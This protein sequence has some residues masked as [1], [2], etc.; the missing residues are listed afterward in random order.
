MKLTIIL[1]SR[2]R[3]SLLKNLLDSIEK[4][5]YDL[6]NIEL[7]CS[8]DNDDLETQWFVQ[9]EGHLYKWANFEFI[10]RDRRLHVRLNNLAS[11][12]K[13][14]FIWVLNDDCEIIT[15][16]YDQQL[17]NL[18]KNYILYISTNCT[19]VDKEKTA[20]Y[21]SFP[22][23]SRKAFK[24][25]G[26][27]MHPEILGLGADVHLWR[28]FNAA[29]KIIKLPIEVKHILHETVQLVCS[30]DETA[31]EMRNNV[32]GFDFWNCDINEDLKKIV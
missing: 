3:P 6:N 31:A 11:R 13:G 4:N 22:M 18:S 21:S 19:S 2:K 7:L 16:N 1:N 29:E 10:E 27:F 15:K 26:Y 24:N 20:E 17:I 9:N 23:L 14:D 25:L 5:T 28:L 32:S 8:C 12:S 30:P